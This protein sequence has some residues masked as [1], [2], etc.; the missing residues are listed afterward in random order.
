MD[1]NNDG[2]YNLGPVTLAYAAGLA[3][4]MKMLRQVPTDPRPF[5]WFM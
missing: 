4:V 1:W 3:R 5:R 2:L